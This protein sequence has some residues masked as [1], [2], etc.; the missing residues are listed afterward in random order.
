[1]NYI[2]DDRCPLCAQP[3][4]DLLHIESYC[5]VALEQGRYTWR[6]NEV[7]RPLHH[8]IGLRARSVR[9]PVVVKPRAMVFVKE[10]D[11]QR[12]PTA[13]QRMPALLDAANDWHITVD[14]PHFTYRFPEII[15]VTAKKP[16]LVLWS[17]SLKLIILIELTV[18][19]ERNVIQAFQRK[20]Q[21]YDGPGALASDCRDAGWAVEV[22]PMEVGT[23]GFISEATVRAC[24]KLGVWSN[25]LRRAL[26]DVALR[27]SYVL[28]LER[29]SPGW[30][31]EQRR[32]WR[33]KPTGSGA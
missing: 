5:R 15:A 18:P 23:L 4:C 28:F 10:G 20:Q 31:G 32:L 13:R 6:H 29:K 26:E 9:K 33:P 17:V 25:E 12:K 24:K 8:Y 2:A 27:A 21:R 3:R 7:L 30:C 19:A 1:M 14:L 22:M 11:G 16:D